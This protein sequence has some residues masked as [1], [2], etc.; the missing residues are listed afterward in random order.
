V[1]EV[2]AVSID[3]LTARHGPPDV[4]FLDVEGFEC[5]A[6][7]GALRTFGTGPDWF[8]EVHVACG[9]EA[10]GG[11]A[12]QVLD[13]F[14]AVDFDRFIHSEGDAVAVPVDAAPIE[15]RRTRFFLTAVNRK[16]TL[17]S[18]R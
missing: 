10:A 2:P 7:E 9:L 13:K 5:R 6:L 3:T 1:F 12:E 17:G 18:P 14:P 8:V 11:S 16:K 4:V 15:K